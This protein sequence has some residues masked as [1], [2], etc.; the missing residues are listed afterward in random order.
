[1]KYKILVV[2]D[3]KD[4]LSILTTLF[5]TVGYTVLTAADGLEAIRM[6]SQER[7][8]LILLD[9]MIPKKNG[10][11]VCREIKS[12]PKTKEIPILILTAKGDRLSR[13]QGLAAG[14]AGYFTK[15]LDPGAILQKIMEQLSPV[16]RGA[17]NPAARDSGK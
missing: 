12:D 9:L 3:N 10:I 2:E 13:E 11:D 4:T 8:S 7:P 1:M 5:D 16:K 15:P 6:A 17:R 14:A